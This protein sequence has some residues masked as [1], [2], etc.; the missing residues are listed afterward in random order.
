MIQMM[1]AKEIHYNGI[2]K[3]LCKT[4][5]D[6]HDTGYEENDITYEKYGDKLAY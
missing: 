2:Y 3:K 4:I 1:E 6:E 5:C